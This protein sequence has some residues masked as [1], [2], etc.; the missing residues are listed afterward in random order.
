V[1]NPNHDPKLASF[2]TLRTASSGLPPKALLKRKR[3]TV[4]EHL[5]ERVKSVRHPVQIAVRA[6]TRDEDDVIRGIAERKA[7]ACY[8]GPS[9]DKLVRRSAGYGAWPSTLLSWKTMDR[10]KRSNSRA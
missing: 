3:R 9:A 4:S 1:T 10:Q 2:I 5:I 6:T 7:A 8:R